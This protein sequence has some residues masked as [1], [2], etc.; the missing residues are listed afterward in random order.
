[1][2]GHEREALV[3]QHSVD[4]EQTA[5]QVQHLYDGLEVFHFCPEL[6]VNGHRFQVGWVKTGKNVMAFSGIGSG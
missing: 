1:M 5:L 4:S 3:W 6:K 2:A